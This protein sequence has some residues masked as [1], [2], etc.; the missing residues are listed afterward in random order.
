MNS[1]QTYRLLR[2][3]DV[4]FRFEEQTKYCVISCLYF[5]G[6]RNITAICCSIV[7]RLFYQ[8]HADYTYSAHDIFIFLQLSV[9]FVRCIFNTRLNLCTFGMDCNCTVVLSEGFYSTGR[10][11]ESGHVQIFS[12]HTFFKHF[13]HVF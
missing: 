11:T 2:K 5:P 6:E 7:P 10:V 4:I 12:L 8:L 1:K 3:Y 9:V 13:E